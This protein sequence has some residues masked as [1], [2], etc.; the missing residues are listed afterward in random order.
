MKNCLVCQLNIDHK[1]EDVVLMFV[2]G[3]EWCL[4]LIKVRHFCRG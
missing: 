1:K 4:L 2:A 3:H